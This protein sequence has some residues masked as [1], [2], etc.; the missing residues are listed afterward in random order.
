M[1]GDDNRRRRTGIG[2]A[3]AYTPRGRTTRDTDAVDRSQE[4]IRYARR[5][6]AAAPEREPGRRARREPQ[7]WEEDEFPAP[8]RGRDST[9]RGGRWD[10]GDRDHT[11]RPIERGAVR[12]RRAAPRGSARERAKRGTRPSPRR[13]PIKPVVT[14]TPPRLGRPQRRLR[15]ATALSLL[16]FAIIG[17]RLI[18]LQ[19]TDAPAYAAEGLRGRLDNVVL[20]A[21]RGAIL[22]RTGAVLAHS[23]EARYV[24]A[25]PELVTDPQAYAAQLS[26]LLGIAA[27]ELAAKMQKKRDELGKQRNFEWLK[28]GVDVE[29]AQA[30][31]NLKLKGII[32]DRDERRD[33][34]GDDLAAN[35]IG[36]TGTDLNGLG[37]IEARFD[38]LLRGRDG[39]FVFERGQG[40]LRKPIP[41]G[42]QL[43]TPPK[44]GKSLKL[45]IDRDV[46]F[47]TQRI[48]ADRMRDKDATWAAAIVLDTR[49]GE[50]IAQASYPTFSA[51]NALAAKASDRVDMATSA[52]VDP[53]SIH[54][55]IVLAA[56]LEEG[57]ITPATTLEV[58][59]T[60]RKGDTTFRDG[61][62]FPEGTRLTLPGLMAYSSNVGTIKVV[63]TLGAQKL[64]DYQR[65]FG[66]GKPTG[67]GVPGEAAG[68]VQPPENWSG[69]SHGSIPI[70]HSVAVT[71]LQ[72]AAVYAAI[73]NDGVWV[74]PH[75]IKEICEPDGKVTPAEA[76]K[77]HRVISAENAA[78][79]RQIMEAV[80]VVDD[81]TGVTARLAG[82][83]ISGKTGT[84]TQ[85]KDGKYLPGEV[86]SF[87]G[88]APADQPRYVIAVFAH[89][90]GG[91]GGA[92]AGPAFR[93]MMGYTLRHFKVPPTG[94]KPPEFVITA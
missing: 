75:L 85:V 66:L 3:R 11:G 81:A 25:D 36:F 56:A 67:I 22:D 53:G 27:S 12:E 28:R 34:P 16:L 80:T 14:V 23:V 59:P 6:N 44:P 88:M 83:R 62:P 38:E 87:I 31:S 63:E 60:I 8:R 43:V 30:I 2:Q 39:K 78:A 40:E 74:Q 29:Q 91:G 90:P 61:H 94:T 82:Y 72:M 49:T 15:L 55:A 20:P 71:P 68:L 86:A 89:T 9:G 35:I 5:E 47:M 84:G 10:S 32:V 76:P 50:V 7:D 18:H 57:A 37:G 58:G 19:L 79:L 77:S 4:P 70:G 45:T 65:L 24:A 26:P 52:V 46:Q 33:A 64:Y 51:K 54:K 42:Y 93:D 21:P 1:A 73:A 92:V 17:F 69:S 48:L 13:R 41:G